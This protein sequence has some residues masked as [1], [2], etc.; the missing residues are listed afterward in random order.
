MSGKRNES[1]DLSGGERWLV[2]SVDVGGPH[3]SFGGSMFA[4]V[5]RPGKN[6]VSMLVAVV[7]VRVVSPVLA[8]GM[9]SG[10]RAS[11]LTLDG[12][13]GAAAAGHP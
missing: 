11:E 8:G 9:V 7:V 13:L 12:P 10:G 6:R 1:P 2:P 3:R 4:V 5:I